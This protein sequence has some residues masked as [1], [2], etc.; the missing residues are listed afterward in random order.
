MSHGLNALANTDA[1]SSGAAPSPST[2]RRPDKGDHSASLRMSHTKT[3]FDLQERLRE[4]VKLAREQGY[5]TYD[6]IDKALPEGMVDPDEMD[7]IFAQLRSM[8]VDI[9]ESLRV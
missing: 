9:I 4:L 2:E 6:D 3:G 8:E 5:L 1:E 7:Q